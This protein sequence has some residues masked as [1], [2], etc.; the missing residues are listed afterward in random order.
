MSVWP[1][2]LEC[3]SH[4]GEGHWRTD[5]QR[6]DPTR[7]GFG[8]PGQCGS[9][10]FSSPW[11]GVMRMVVVGGGLLLCSALFD[12]QKRFCISVKI[13][14]IFVNWYTLLEITWLIIVHALVPSLSVTDLIRLSTAPRACFLFG[15]PFLLSWNLHLQSLFFVPTSFPSRFAG[16]EENMQPTQHILVLLLWVLK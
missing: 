10:H 13:T 2:W 8:R 3:A 4:Q 6:E 15:P 16:W 9:C 5:Q 14:C 12:A 7:C 11:S 1:L